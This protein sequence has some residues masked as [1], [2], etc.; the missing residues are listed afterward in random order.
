MSNIS[1]EELV[2]REKECSPVV[3]LISCPGVKRG[4]RFRSGVRQQTAMENIKKNMQVCNDYTRCTVHNV[5]GWLKENGLNS[6]EQDAKSW[7]GVFTLMGGQGFFKIEWL[8]L[9]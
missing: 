2:T 6:C 8:I 4:E 7:L 1:L 3:H 9:P 5:L